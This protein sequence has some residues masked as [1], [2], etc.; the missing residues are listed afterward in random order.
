VHHGSGELPAEC[1]QRGGDLGEVGRVA[2]GTTL[3]QRSFEQF[4]EFGVLATARL[5]D[6]REEQTSLSP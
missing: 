5:L 3:A 6:R 4:G 2:G 1:G